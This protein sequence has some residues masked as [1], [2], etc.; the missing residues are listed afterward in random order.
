MI[1]I[2]IDHNIEGHA[3]RVWDAF[4]AQGWSDVVSLNML[5][6]D[7][8]DLAFDSSDRDV[9]RFAQ[10]QHMVLL[11]AN[12][13]MNEADSLEQTLREENGP[14]SLPVLTIGNPNRISQLG[15]GAD[16]SSVG[17]ILRDSQIVASRLLR[18]A[19]EAGYGSTRPGPA[20]KRGANCLFR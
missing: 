18:I 6:F 15:D 11:T 19:H 4:Q 14:T 3:L 1:T 9:W 12:R 2:L 13:N 20:C 10:A 7:A 16:I 8:V 5:T 17:N